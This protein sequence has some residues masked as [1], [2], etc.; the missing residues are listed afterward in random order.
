VINHLGE[1]ARKFCEWY[2]AEEGKDPTAALVL[3]VLS[4]VK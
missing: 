2:R 4:Q 3:N 1:D